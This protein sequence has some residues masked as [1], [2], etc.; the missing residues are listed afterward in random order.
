MRILQVYGLLCLSCSVLLGG[1]PPEHY[2]P[3]LT[4]KE[5]MA[6]MIAPSANALW[7]SVATYIQ[8]NHF[9]E[10]APRKDADWRELRRRAIVVLNAADLLLVSGRHV[11]K[12]G[13]KS[14]NP[15]I[16]LHPK[17]I[18]KLISEDRAAWIHLTHTLQNSVV[19]V[20]DAIDRKDVQALQFSGN[21][22]NGACEQC[23]QKYWYPNRK[24]SQQN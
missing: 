5:I 22:M 8:K 2:R 19:L 6:S 16:E 12:P 13:E 15:K 18:E 4:I 14:D 17:Q 7:D 11:A 10:K 24:K 20:L 21:V 9:E 1:R 3:D 23:H